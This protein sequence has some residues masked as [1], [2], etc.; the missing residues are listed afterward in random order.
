MIN[1]VAGRRLQPW[2]STLQAIQMSEKVVVIQD[3]HPSF[4]LLLLLLEVSKQTLLPFPSVI[5]LTVHHRD[6]EKSYRSQR[7]GDWGSRP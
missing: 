5:V 7:G 2:F 3:L 1:P 4:V 6:V